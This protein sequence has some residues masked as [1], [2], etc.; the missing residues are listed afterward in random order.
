VSDDDDDDDGASD[1]QLGDVD[2][3][4]LVHLHE[5]LDTASVTEAARRLG[6]TQSA[7]SHALRRLRDLLDDKLL[8]RGRQGMMR[9]PRAEALREPLYRSLLALQD[10]LTRHERFV[11]ERSDRTFRLVITD[12]LQLVLLPRIVEIVEREAPGVQLHVESL[13]EP[14]QFLPRLLSGDVDLATGGPLLP[15]C[16]EIVREVLLEDRLCCAVRHDHPRVGP[17][18]GLDDY[19]ALSHVL[20]SPSGTG[21]GIVDEKLAELGLQRRIAVRVQSF[22]SAPFLVAASDTVL[23]APVRIWRVYAEPLGLR[24]LEAPV[25]LERFELTLLW[26]ERERHDAALSWLRRVIT[27]AAQDSPS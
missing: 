1:I 26:S 10:T 23:T 25:E 4:L 27:R 24:L 19:L 16:R 22:L 11:P 2:V 7:M 13:S 8:V 18:L 5:L 20:I 6:I 9:T 17:R 15:T 12:Y 3:N 21:L 14:G